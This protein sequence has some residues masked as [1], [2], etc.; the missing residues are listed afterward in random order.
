MIRKLTFHV[1]YENVD[2]M[3]ALIRENRHSTLCEVAEEVGISKSQ[4]HTILTENAEYRAGAKFVP[5][6]LK[7]EQKANRGSQFRFNITPE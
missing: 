3:R 5:C 6:L 4:C 7:D 1:I 2:K